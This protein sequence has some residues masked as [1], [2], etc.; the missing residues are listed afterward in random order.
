LIVRRVTPNESGGI[1]PCRS[2]KVKYGEPVSMLG[3]V[4]GKDIQKTKV[5]GGL[6]LFYP[7]TVKE[8]DTKETHTPLSRLADS[9]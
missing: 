6:M 8:R 1:E 3:V 2:D 7:L 9:S 4:K 5:E